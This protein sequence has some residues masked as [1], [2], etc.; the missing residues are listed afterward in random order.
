MGKIKA[1][2]VRC[3]RTVF[4][5]KRLQH[6]SVIFVA[7]S[8]F[9]VLQC[10]THG[11]AVASTDAQ[12]SFVRVLSTEGFLVDSI[13]QLTAVNL[14]G[15]EQDELL[16]LGKNYEA[17]ETFLYV[18][19]WYQQKFRVL[20]KSP[21]LYSSPGHTVVAAGDFM[22]VGYPQVLLMGDRKDTLLRWSNGRLQVVW[23]GDSRL[24]VQDITCLP[25]GQGE[26][27]LLVATQVVKKTAEYAVENLNVMRWTENGF[28]ILASSEPIGVIRSVAA[29]AITGN[30]TSEI[31]IDTGNGTKA[32]NQ[33]VWRFDGKRL[34]RLANQELATAAAFGLG[35]FPEGKK[36]AI[37]DDRG[38]VR[39]F[40]WKDNGLER[41]GDQVSLG[42]ALV[43]LVVGRF[44]ADS[45]A[46]VIVVAE[47]PN[48]I[49][50][51]A[52]SRE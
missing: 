17:R 9:A 40:V 3:Y 35:V 10:V 15:S 33:Q 11:V 43:S 28:E 30:K 27:D 52:E 2:P 34:V 37:G 12:M 21:N 1:I 31:I 39:F 23:E 18:L 26:Q 14:M 5:R 47:Y 44:Y 32:G 50:L 36:V 24:A 51:L 29:G 13:L 6:L 38:K 48:V 19:D 7:V 41:V 25:Q 42:W 46:P 8:V 16:L 49:H 4:A 20:W 22:G 45:N